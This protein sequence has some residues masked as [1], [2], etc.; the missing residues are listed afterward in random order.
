MFDFDLWVCS[1]N[2]PAAKKPRKNPN[3]AAIVEAVED[4]EEC[5]NPIPQN[6]TDT[7]P[8][9]IVLPP[10]TLAQRLIEVPLKERWYTNGA[11][12]SRV[13]PEFQR[14]IRCVFTLKLI[15]Y[16]GVFMLI[17]SC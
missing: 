13:K 4:I 14:I 12:A 5:E 6:A 1:P 17:T 2:T 11:N 7:T 9:D 3:L 15:T 10:T 16:F 8:T